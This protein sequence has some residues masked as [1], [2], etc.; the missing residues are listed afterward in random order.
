M[1]QYLDLIQDVLDNGEEHDDRTGTGTRSVFARHVRFD[2]SKGFP[3]VTTKRVP[4]KAVYGELLWF[5]EGSTDERRL[6]EITFGTRDLDKKTIWTDNAFANYWKDYASF[7]GDC[8]RIYGIQWRKWRGTEIVKNNWN[9]KVE[10]P[11]IIDQI[12]NVIKSIKDDPSGRRHVVMAYNP[13]E[14][15]Q[16]VLPPC[17]MF[18]QF[19]VSNKKK[20][21][22][23]FYMRSNDVFL[24]LPFNIASYALLTHMMAQVCGLEAGELIY[25][26]GD[27]HLYQ[28]HI[29]QAIEQ[30]SREP[31]PLPRIE[32][33]PTIMDI[34]DFKLDSI[35]LVDYKCHPAIKAP[36]AV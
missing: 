27:V 23:Q 1:K 13:G 2:L 22:C 9:K 28:N 31:Y 5:L 18:F 8:G 17:H 35:K 19:W 12:K 20:L 14:L 15:N 36:M 11:I 33:D 30:L 4:F 24:G 25:T 3:L 32:I 29:D 6:A 34:D 26:A 7:F 10:E 21:C 16:M